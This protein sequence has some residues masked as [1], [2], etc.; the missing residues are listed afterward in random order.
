[1]TGFEAAQKAEAGDSDALKIWQDYGIH[2]GQLIQTT[3]F[4]YDP[5]AIIF[6][7]G[8]TAAYPLFEESM[9][10]NLK[11]FPYPK[12]LVNLQIKISSNPDIAILGAAALVKV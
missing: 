11:L 4:T 3:L 9:R 12:S 7:G 1:M 5:D 10:E 2:L 6:G 8:I